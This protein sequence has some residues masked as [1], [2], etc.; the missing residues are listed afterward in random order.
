MVTSLGLVTLSSLI[1]LAGSIVSF[2]VAFVVL[3][4]GV[5][6]Y[7]VAGHAWISHRVAYRWRARAI[8]IF[9][10]SWAL[11]MLLGAPIV[12]LL[13]NRFGWRGP[14]VALAIGSMMAAF[15]VALVLPSPPVPRRRP[16]HRR[17]HPSGR[18][19]RATCVDGRR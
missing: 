4:L 11:A 15:V 10:I 1:A 2:A 6:N 16:H 7:T 18:R 14:F 17:R 3:V 9:E 19:A 5:A 12:A 13:I 8:G